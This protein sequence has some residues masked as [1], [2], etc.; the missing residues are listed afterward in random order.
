MC[1]V[2]DEPEEPREP[3]SRPALS[4]YASPSGEKRGLGVGVGLGRGLRR[5]FV[6]EFLLTAGFLAQNSSEWQC[7]AGGPLR[8]IS[9]TGLVWFIVFALVASDE[10][11]PLMLGTGPG[12][13]WHAEQM[14]QCNY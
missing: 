8:Q 14:I 6:F 4:F 3:R 11:L 13:V 5:S 9:M 12:R 2:W 1:H 7:S 10:R